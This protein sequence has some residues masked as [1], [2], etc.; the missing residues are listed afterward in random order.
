MNTMRNKLTDLQNYLFAQ[1]ERLEDEDMTKE[2]LDLE[3]KRTKAITSIATAIINNGA[4]CLQARQY[5]AD[6][7]SANKTLPEIL[8]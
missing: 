5:I 1:L 2:T 8:E 7:E 3:L 4:L 6:K